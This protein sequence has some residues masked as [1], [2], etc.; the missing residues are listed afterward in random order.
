MDEYGGLRKKSVPSVAVLGKFFPAPPT[1]FRRTTRR[2]FLNLFSEKI[3]L[4]MATTPA[5]PKPTLA[6]LG[7]LS[8]GSTQSP[9]QASHSNDTDKPVTPQKE[10]EKKEHKK[11]KENEKYV[12]G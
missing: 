3:T 12:G 7:E 2:V 4:D 8:D 1:R 11:V 5:K 10:L 9:N 6:D